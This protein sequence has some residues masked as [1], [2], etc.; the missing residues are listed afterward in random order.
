M[1][2]QWDTGTK[3]SPDSE[4]LES[5]KESVELSIIANDPC[6]LLL[7]PIQPTPSPHHLLT[8]SV[9]SVSSAA[10]ARTVQLYKRAMRSLDRCFARM[11]CDTNDVEAARLWGEELADLLVSILHLSCPCPYTDDSRSQMAAMGFDLFKV[12][13]QLHQRLITANELL[14]HWLDVSWLEWARPAMLMPRTQEADR[15]QKEATERQRLAREQAKR[16]AEETCIAD[17]KQAKE[18]AA[19][20]RS[21]VA[22]SSK[23][24]AKRPMPRVVSKAN[25]LTEDVEM[26]SGEESEQ[27]LGALQGKSTKEELKAAW[28]AIKA[29]QTPIGYVEV[30][31]RILPLLTLN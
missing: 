20:Q 14:D 10:V 19:A 22:G 18:I 3:E 17:E 13:D 27:T 1:I 21:T 7:T 9:S 29:G 6:P 2:E 12:D 4:S 11:P 23:K 30:C 31:C 8:R 26:G 25:A 5:Y 28:A 16:L 24:P 15:R